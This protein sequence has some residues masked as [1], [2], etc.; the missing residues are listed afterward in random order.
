MKSDILERW[1]SE[2]LV[3]YVEDTGLQNIVSLRDVQEEDGVNNEDVDVGVL[4]SKV[5]LGLGASS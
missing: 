1:R 3:A 5:V 2:S 4:T